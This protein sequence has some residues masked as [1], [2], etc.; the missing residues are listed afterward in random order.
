MQGSNFYDKINESAFDSFGG[1]NYDPDFFEDVQNEYDPDYAG[2]LSE[3][4]AT[5]LESSR[6]GQVMQINITLSN[7][8][9]IKQKVELFSGFNSWADILKSEYSQGAYTS[10]PALS[11]QGLATVGVGTVGYDQN[12]DLRKY[13]AAGNP[14]VSIGCGEYPYKS[15]VESSKVLPFKVNMMRIAVATQQQLNNQIVHFTRTFGGGVKQNQIN[16]RSYKSPYQQQSL[17]VDTLAPFIINGEKG[18]SYDL[19]I[20]EVVQLGL[21]INK[22]ARPAV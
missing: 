21:F 16:V 2:Q 4:S 7:P 11:T 22:W 5:R 12:G 19:E 14:S 1:N 8:S 3:K 13:G 15:L 17:E 18:L 20:G 6:P 9:A 10:I